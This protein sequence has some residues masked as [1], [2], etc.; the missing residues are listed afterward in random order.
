MKLIAHMGVCVA[1]TTKS[2]ET[3]WGDVRRVVAKFCGIH[4][5]LWDLEE[6]GNTDDN[7]MQ[8]AIDLYMQKVVYNP[9]VYKQFLD[10]VLHPLIIRSCVWPHS[11]YG[12]SDKGPQS[13]TN[14]RC[15]RF[16]C[17]SRVCHSCSSTQS[18]GRA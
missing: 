6:Q 17:W 5:S 2:I 8:D 1:C 15:N 11:D 14:R 9:F 13:S 16:W 4:R 18:E 10:F 3:K 12:E 7:I